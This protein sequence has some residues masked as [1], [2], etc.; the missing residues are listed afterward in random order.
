MS[1][2]YKNLINSLEQK[3]EL[4]ATFL[5]I[6]KLE[7]NLKELQ[8]RI[9]DPNLWNDQKKAQSLLREE[10]LIQ[11]KL[12]HYANI[13]NDFVSN[14]ELAEL[15]ESE[16][17]QTVFQDAIYNLES[18]L[19]TCD[20][21]EIE[22]LFEGEADFNNA[23]LEINAGAGGTESHDW[24]LMLL[25]MYL[26]WAEHNK[27]KTEI[28]YEL[29]GEEAG[30]KNATIKI[31]G[32]Y[33]YGWLKNESG[34]HRLVRNS[35]FNA[36]GKRQTSFASVW[37]YPEVDDSIEI[38]IIEKDLRIDTFRASGAGGQHVNKTES[39]VRITHL[40]TGIAVSSQSD[41]SQ[42]K[43][44]AECYKMLK[45]RLYELE[46]KKKEE[47]LNKA[48]QSKTEIGWGHQIR[49]YVLQPYQLVKD[50]RT[51][52]ETGDAGAVLDG[53]IN[54]F[55]S[56]SLKQAVLSKNQQNN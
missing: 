4:L 49:S 23:F 47:E 14:K 52:Y 30:I 5:D 20:N 17:D 45:A 40:P 55:L 24:A 12:S 10:K 32:N 54:E 26:R 1:I 11:N 56:A 35:P 15:A 44:K 29:D 38:E 6:E 42:H 31:S 50:L 27:F 7:I 28:L 37:V 46:L 51:D 41:R 39:A 53:K 36:Q 8:E 22:C 9:D 3:I 2:E 21:L 16:Q 25:R 48:N 43:N 34:V 13:Q 33:A 19:L 18:V